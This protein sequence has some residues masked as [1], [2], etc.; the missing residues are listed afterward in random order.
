MDKQLLTNLLRNDAGVAD[1]DP[2]SSTRV[3]WRQVRCVFIDWRIYLYALIAVGDNA[4]IRCL[5][6]FLPSLVEAMGYSRTTAHLMT[7]PPYA[8]ACICSL[9]VGYS[10]S[11][12]NEHGYHLAFCLT[13]GLLGFI[14]LLTLFDQGK[15]T[16]YITTTIGFCG[17][18]SAL[19]LILSWLTNNVGGHTK[20]AMAISFVIGIAQIGGIVTPLVRLLR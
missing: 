17:S 5:V 20:R 2:T 13:V 16:I 4:V 18:I 6:T 8:V 3:S 19:S 7:A 1:S 15:V 14:L 9:L 11:R 12:R 10:S